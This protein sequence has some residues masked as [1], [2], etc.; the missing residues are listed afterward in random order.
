M[1]AGGCPVVVA[2]C[3]AE[4][5]AAQARCPGFDSQRLPAFHFSASKV[6]VPFGQSAFS[7]SLKAKK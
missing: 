3:M 5:M 2:Q 6:S 4:H 1:R 7:F